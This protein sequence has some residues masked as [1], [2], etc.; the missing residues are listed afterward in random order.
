MPC[1]SCGGLLR[2]AVLAL[3]RG[4]QRLTSQH[5]LCGGLDIVRQVP[6]GIG[7]T[8]V[9]SELLHV[10]YV[11]LTSA[12][13]HVQP[14]K[15]DPKN[16]ATLQGDIPE[17]RGDRKGFTDFVRVGPDRPNPLDTEQLSSEARYFG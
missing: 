8:H 16:S 10:H 14:V 6:W 12:H 4:Q 2:S 11:G 13:H 1:R 5:A 15:V 3:A 9:A 7:H 17:F